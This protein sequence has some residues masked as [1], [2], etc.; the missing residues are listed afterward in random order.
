MLNPFSVFVF[1]KKATHSDL[2]WLLLSEYWHSVLML[3]SNMLLILIKVMEPL[4]LLFLR[5]LLLLLVLLMLVLIEL[6]L[7]KTLSLGSTFMI[8]FTHS[9]QLL[10]STMLFV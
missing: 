10:L 8:Y 1:C 5:L 3:F 7:L 4:L 2:G 6:L 9:N